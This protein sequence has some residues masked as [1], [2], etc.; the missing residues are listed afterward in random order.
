M[1]STI[2]RETQ[3][4]ATVKRGLHGFTPIGMA[5]RKTPDNDKFR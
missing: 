1:P 3:V 2:G 5:G 4:K